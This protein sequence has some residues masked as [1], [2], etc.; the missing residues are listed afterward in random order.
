MPSLPNPLKIA[1]KGA[2]T[3]FQI[4]SFVAGQAFERVQSL[5]GGNGHDDTYSPTTPDR[6]QSPAKLESVKDEGTTSTGL[7]P[8]YSQSTATG[9]GG[10]N[11]MAP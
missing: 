9:P 6:T 2:E 11:R 10:T 7:K 5:V 8:T 4:G 3:A 1:T